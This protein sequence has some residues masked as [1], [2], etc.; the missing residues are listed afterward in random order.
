MLMVL[1]VT[2]TVMIVVWVMVAAVFL[3]VVFA[4]MAEVSLGKTCTWFCDKS[5]LKAQR[6]AQGGRNQS[7]YKAKA[8]ASH[9]RGER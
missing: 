2:T 1:A 6:K 3:Q 4:V 8:R 9:V 5:R 7:Y